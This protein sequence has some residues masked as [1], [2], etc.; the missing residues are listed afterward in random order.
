MSIEEAAYLTLKSALINGGDVHIFDMGEPIPLAEII[1]NLQ[2]ILGQRSSVLIT[3]LRDGEKM[4]EDLVGSHEVSIETVEPRIT[5]TNLNV[6]LKSNYDLVDQI[7][8]R[9]ENFIIKNLT[10]MTTLVTL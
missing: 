3:G 4:S 1:E 10:A 9:N 2:V 6:E 8:S 7:N 5:C